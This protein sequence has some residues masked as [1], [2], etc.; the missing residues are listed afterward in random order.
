MRRSCE[1]R[2]HPPAAHPGRF[3]ILCFLRSKL[4]GLSAACSMIAVLLSGSCAPR[5]IERP[6]SPVPSVSRAVPAAPSEMELNTSYMN[7]VVELQ[8]LNAEMNAA[9]DA[10][11]FATVREKA[12]AG[13]SKAREARMV[14]SQLRDEVLRRQRFAA[15]DIT[16]R[17]L[18]RLV[19]ITSQ[20]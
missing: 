12:L 20:Q 19:A 16:I 5:K 1:L 15:I 9:N 18:E 10:R 11:D 7:T 6:F 14:A 3:P 2:L 8:R 17:D 13:L 4:S